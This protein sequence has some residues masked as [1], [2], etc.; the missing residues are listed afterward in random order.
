MA[1]GLRDQLDVA[2]LHADGL[3]AESC[4]AEN[5]DPDVTQRRVGQLLA[6]VAVVSLRLA[7]STV[8]ERRAATGR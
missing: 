3:A 7:A 4:R 6:S 8:R 5:Q 2:E 1:D